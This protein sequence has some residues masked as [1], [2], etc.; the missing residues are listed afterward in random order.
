MYLQLLRLFRLEE[1]PTFTKP[2]DP[3]LYLHRF[4][5]KLGFGTKAREVQM[6]ALN[7]VSGAG[8]IET[9]IGLRGCAC[10]MQRRSWGLAARHE[11]CRWQDWVKREASK[12]MW[13]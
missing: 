7:L 5:E 13:A 1:Y 3:S 8:S 2:I 12:R 6:T 11:G 9:H 4:T 10:H